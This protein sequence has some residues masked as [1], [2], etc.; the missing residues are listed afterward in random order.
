MAESRLIE[1][2]YYNSKVERDFFVRQNNLRLRYFVYRKEK[3]HRMEGKGPL[4][5]YTDIFQTRNRLHTFIAKDHK[6]VLLPRNCIYCNGI[7]CGGNS[8]RRV[9]FGP[10]GCALSIQ[11]GD[12]GCGERPSP[13]PHPRSH[14]GPS[15]PARC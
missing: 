4:F 8:C 13:A 2:S 6:I 15:C 9:R 11:R 1:L 10:L 14:T 12:A 7:W 5:G 3:K